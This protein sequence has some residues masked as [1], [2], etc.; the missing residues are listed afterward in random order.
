MQKVRLLVC[1]KARLTVMA[2]IAGVFLLVIILVAVITKSQCNCSQGSPTVQ[3]SP[4]I[5]QKCV[6]TNGKKFPYQNILLPKAIVPD[7]YQIF[8]HPNISES[9]F[10]G[11]VNITFSVNSVTDFIVFHIKDLNITELTVIDLKSGTQ[12]PVTER[13]ECKSNEQVYVRLGTSLD[14]AKNST[15]LSVGFVGNLTEKL[16]GFYKSMYKTKAGEKR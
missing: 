5:D 10:Q 2:V 9:I 13:L 3:E 4:K 1:N 7:T 8:M 15:K 6:A 11:E 12:I 16:A 14:V